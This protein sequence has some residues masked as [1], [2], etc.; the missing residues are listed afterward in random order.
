MGHKQDVLVSIKFTSGISR[1]DFP[2]P[3][4]VNVSFISLHELSIS[5]EKVVAF[6]ENPVPKARLK[7][8]TAH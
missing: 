3:Q 8:V 7:T 1:N 2:V 4:D 5:N 6:H